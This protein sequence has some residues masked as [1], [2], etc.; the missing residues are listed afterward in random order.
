MHRPA[1]VFVLL[2]LTFCFLFLATHAQQQPP[3]AAGGGTASATCIPQERD[4][5]L[6]FKHALPETGS[7]PWAK[8]F[9]VGQ[10]SGTRQRS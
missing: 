7:L 6:A 3:P 4:A 2:V 1:A 9:A 10:K 5:L 8:P